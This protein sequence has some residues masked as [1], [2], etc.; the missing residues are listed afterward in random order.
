ME[1]ELSELDGCH[2]LNVC[3]EILSQAG[4]MN[5]ELGSSSLRTVRVEN[6]SDSSLLVQLNIKRVGESTRLDI[7]ASRF[8]HRAALLGCDSDSEER[9]AADFMSVLQTV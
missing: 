2:I 7:H 4:F 9:L 1:L 3:E 5:G 8:Y 6:H